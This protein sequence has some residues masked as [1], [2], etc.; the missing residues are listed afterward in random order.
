MI[1]IATPTFFLFWGGGGGWVGGGGGMM[2]TLLFMMKASP[3]QI[4]IQEVEPFRKI[5][6]KASTVFI[7]NWRQNTNSIIKTQSV[8]DTWPC[9]VYLRQASPKNMKS[10]FPSVSTSSKGWPIIRWNDV[11]MGTLPSS[12]ASHLFFFF[13]LHFSSCSENNQCQWIACTGWL[14]KIL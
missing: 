13:F 7:H 9:D 8:N 2:L 1:L 14:C 5:S 11:S 12:A 10:S 4:W 3:Y 6:T